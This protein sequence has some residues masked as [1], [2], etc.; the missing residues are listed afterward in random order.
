MERCLVNVSGF[1]AT[2]KDATFN[3]LKSMSGFV[4]HS[5][6]DVYR[7]MGMIQPYTLEQ[8][9]RA[10]AEF[11]EIL[12]G[13]MVEQKDILC[14]KNLNT[15]KTR[16]ALYEVAKNYCYDICVVRCICSDEEAIKRINSRTESIADTKV[17]DPK[18]YFF[19]K[20]RYECIKSDTEVRN[21]HIGLME[22]DTQNNSI[23]IITKGNNPQLTENVFEHLIKELNNLGLKLP[24]KT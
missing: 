22:F 9:Q 8:T 16:K 24:F 5:I 23:E 15:R 10:Y 14:Q 13:S 7:Q 21:N 11:L 3:T 1:P 19:V 18:V 20:K 17:L 4:T 2:G 12:E 6:D